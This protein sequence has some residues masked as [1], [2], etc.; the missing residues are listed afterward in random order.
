MKSSS[1]TIIGAGRKSMFFSGGLLVSNLKYSL[2][3]EYCSFCL[4][5]AESG[6]ESE[7]VFDLSESHYET[8]LYLGDKPITFGLFGMLN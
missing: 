8:D 1:F 4:C 5:L 6:Y 3:L 7:G 2:S